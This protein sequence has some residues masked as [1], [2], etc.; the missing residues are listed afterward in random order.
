MFQNFACFFSFPTTS[1][2]ADSASKKRIRIPHNRMLVYTLFGLFFFCFRFWLRRA[3]RGEGR[4]KSSRFFFSRPQ[5]FSEALQSK[6]KGE[7]R[8]ERKAAP[9]SRCAPRSRPRRRAAA[10]LVTERCRPCR[11]RRRRRQQRPRQQRELLLASIEIG[12]A[13]RGGASS[14]S[15][16]RPSAGAPPRPG[17]PLFLCRSRRC[18]S[19]RRLR[20]L[21]ATAEE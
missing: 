18:R 3:K 15:P 9:L 14:S 4:K 20:R 1:P 2:A 12:F 5:H 21:A 16:R 13:C 19:R 6:K 10:V 17:R 7:R 11:H 8:L